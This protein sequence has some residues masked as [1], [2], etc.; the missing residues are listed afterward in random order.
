MP[1]T[2]DIEAY[3][4]ALRPRVIGQEFHGVRLAS[5]FLLRTV[6][7]P[8]GA[9]A[10][11]RVE[12]VERLGKRVVLEVGE[13][14]DV[15]ASVP[16]PPTPTAPL[17]LVIHLM[18]AGRLHWKKGGSAIP[19]GSG[20]AAFD[21]GTGG[22]ILTEAGK[23]RRASLRLVRGRE[24][25]SDLDPGGMEVLGSSLEEFGAVLR[26]KN[27][28]LKRV[29]TDPHAL[30][31]IGNAYS[32]EILHRARLSPFRRTRTLDAA[33]MAGLHAASLEVLGEWT[34][35]LR[36]EA[37][38]GFP[39]G[40]TAFRPEMAVHGRFGSPCPTCGA[41]IQR[42]AYVDHECDYCPRCQTGG[43]ILADRALSRLSKDD[44]PRGARPHHDPEV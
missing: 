41:A 6:D 42:I 2:P 14:P 19:R 13:L 24:A 22:L 27:R 32:D 10:G 11:G 44:W 40:V 3:I 31:G 30:S 18:I 37:R 33:E 15:T 38:K 16:P 17:F 35:R 34:E 26:E 9:V 25:L 7:P 28:T 39:E 4:E 1:E 12:G 29:L 43:R 8:L 20:L 5:P 23:K 36:A 21:F